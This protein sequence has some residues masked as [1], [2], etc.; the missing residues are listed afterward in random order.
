MATTEDRGAAD[1]VGAWRENVY[2]RA[3]ERSDELFTTISG[4]EN[5]PL[6][7]PDTIDV[8]YARDLGYPGEYPFTRGGVPVDVPRPAVD[9]AA[10]R[11]VRHVED[12]R[13]R[14]PG[15]VQRLDPWA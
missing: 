15:P 10:V 12:P 6:N 4:V 13:G 11:R 3:P 14:T 8:D 9:D 1:S 2:E 5:E 7:T